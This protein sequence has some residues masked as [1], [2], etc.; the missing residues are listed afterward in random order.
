[1]RVAQEEIGGVDKNCAGGIGGGDGESGENR[2]RKGLPD[3]ELLCG[4]GCGGAER[5]ILF[6]EKHLGTNALEAHDHA[7]RN[8]A[9]IETEIV[10]ADAE[11]E[12]MEVKQFVALVVGVNGN[13]DVELAGFRVPIE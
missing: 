8:L 11:G 5:L 6:D 4:I 9:A 3:G 1:M 12:R 10:R 13:L 2:F 7:G